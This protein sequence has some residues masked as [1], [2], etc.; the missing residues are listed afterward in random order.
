MIY[1]V[2]NTEAEAIEAQEYDFKKFMEVYSDRNGYDHSTSN[3]SIPCQRI[4]DNKWV[5]L[6]CPQSDAVYTQEE[7][8][9]SWF[10]SDEE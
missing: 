5:Y 4:T 7:F 1:N 10:E 8:D 3:W 9:E 6:A 2:F